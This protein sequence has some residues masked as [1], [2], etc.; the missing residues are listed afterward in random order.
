MN[1]RLGGYTVWEWGI[2][3]S[4]VVLYYLLMYNIWP[5]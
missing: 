1:R 4:M 3:A 5:R 2:I